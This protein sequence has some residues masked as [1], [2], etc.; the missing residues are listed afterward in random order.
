M[1]EATFG[2]KYIFEGAYERCI[3]EF[4]S[5][6]SKSGSSK[7]GL[8]SKGPGSR[9]SIIVRSSFLL[10]DNGWAVFVVATQA[11]SEKPVDREGT[12]VSVVDFELM[13]LS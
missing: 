6:F 3:P 2:N 12:P 1:Y 5:S 7:G 11:V 4:G 13:R 8:Y 9:S 10:W